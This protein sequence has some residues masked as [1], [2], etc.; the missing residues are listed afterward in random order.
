M[1]IYGQHYLMAPRVGDEAPSFEG[2]SDDGSRVSL[3]DLL[4]KGEVVLYFYPKDETPG[5]TAEACAFRDRW[6][7]IEELGATVVGV[8]SDSVESHASFKAHHRLPFTLVSD[9]GQ[10]IRSLYGAKGK[11]VSPRVT[12]VIGRDGIV[13]HVYRSQVD[14]KSHVEEAIRALAKM[15][16]VSSIEGGRGSAAEDEGRASSH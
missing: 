3:K 1:V 8:S 9:E 16:H 7:K 14:A 15:K 11:F 12:F 10:E 2:I 5:C 13:R 4:S 6:G